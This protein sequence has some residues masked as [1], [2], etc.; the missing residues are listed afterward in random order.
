[1]VDFTEVIVEDH[2]FSIRQRREVHKGS[3]Q[4]TEFVL[5]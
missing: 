2:L 4:S 3:L 1:M 5:E